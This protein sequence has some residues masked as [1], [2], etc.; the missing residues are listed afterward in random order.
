V[1][2]SLFADRRIA[3]CSAASF[4]FVPAQAGIQAKHSSVSKSGSPLPRGRT[5]GVAPR[6]LTYFSC[7]TAQY[8]EQKNISPC[9]GFGPGDRPRSSVLT[10]L[11]SRGMARRQGAR[12]GSPG[13]RWHGLRP[14][15][16]VKRH[17]PRL[18]ARQRGILG[19]RLSQ[20]SGRAR[21]CL[22][23]A[24]FSR[25]RPWA[26]LRNCLPAGCRS[27]SPPCERLR[28]TPLELGSG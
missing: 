19:L 2:K 8:I 12:P 1:T 7:Q 23:L 9:F 20:R 13:R 10:T 4:P 27:R 14:G 5:E 24:G 6:A 11:T 16:G 18:A 28:K 15:L 26:G 21:S 25:G 22:S 3:Q 17:A